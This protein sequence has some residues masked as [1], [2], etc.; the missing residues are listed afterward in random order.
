MG[1]SRE[2]PLRE[3]WETVKDEVMYRAVLTKFTTHQDIKEIL[4]ATGEEHIVENSPIDYYWGCGKDG[5]GKNKL[6]E[7]LIQVR[8]EIRN[9]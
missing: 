2:H 6:G 7:I 3:D 9:K 8:T 1:R 4:L 5:S